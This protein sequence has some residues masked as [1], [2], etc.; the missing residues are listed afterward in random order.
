MKTMMLP[1]TGLLAV[2]PGSVRPI[3][4][5]RADRANQK[6]RGKILPGQACIRGC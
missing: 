2:Q 5:P 3:A 4:P 6:I 1:L